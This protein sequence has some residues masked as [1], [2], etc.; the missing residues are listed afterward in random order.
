MMA[1]VLCIGGFAIFIYMQKE[2]HMHQLKQNRSA[3][4]KAKQVHRFQAPDFS[5]KTLK[6]TSV[7]LH[8]Y[9]GRFVLLNMWASW[10]GP[11]R[12]EAGELR[13]INQRFPAN[14]LVILGIN[15]TSQEISLSKVR[16]FVR[17]YR[18]LFPVLLDK[19]GKVMDRYGVKVLPTSFLIGRDGSVIRQFRGPVSVQEITNAIKKHQRGQQ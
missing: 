6:G 17:Q 14:E 1:I 19:K 8:E 7:S 4:I 5:L 9:H 11:C 18:I 3:Q 2:D 10:C 16:D 12:N 13:K 15:M